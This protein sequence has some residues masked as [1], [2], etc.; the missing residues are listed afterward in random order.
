MCKC[1]L[2]FCHRVTTQLQ[3]T[4]ISRMSTRSW[5][6]NSSDVGIS[7]PALTASAFDLWGFRCAPVVRSYV[8]TTCC[9]VAKD[10]GWVTKTVKSSCN[11]T[12]RK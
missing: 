10:P 3:L 12:D 6:A 2:Y 1:V 7:V 9:I 4:N 5:K 11:R 8:W